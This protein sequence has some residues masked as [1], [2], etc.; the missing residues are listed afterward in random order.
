[1]GRY[2]KIVEIEEKPGKK[3]RNLLVT[4]EDSKGERF[5]TIMDFVFVVGNGQPCISL[6]EA[7]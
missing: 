5:Q 4:L 2:G 3:R 1:M 7:S 6:P